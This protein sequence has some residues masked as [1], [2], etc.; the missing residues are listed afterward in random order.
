MPTRSNQK[1]ASDSE[2]HKKRNV[3]R[4]FF[5]KFARGSGTV[6]SHQHDG[7]VTEEQVVASASSNNN[8]D[9]LSNHPTT[10][11]SPPAENIAV[12]G[13]ETRRVPQ[14]E[15]A[16]NP[17]SMSEARLSNSLGTVVGKKDD[18]TEELP[19]ELTGLQHQN[20]APNQSA[21]NSK[22][23][24]GW[25]IAISMTKLALQLTDKALDGVPVPGAKGAVSG[26]LTI[27]QRIE[28]KS[29]HFLLSLF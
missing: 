10:L 20:D 2:R 18:N 14:M 27:V 6:D 22:S 21:K 19:T 17:S 3:V 13:V 11:E 8:T 7:S 4:K 5:R 12:N 28:V 16:E 9:D 15:I 23:R 26:V 25:T 24:R 29:T 1:P